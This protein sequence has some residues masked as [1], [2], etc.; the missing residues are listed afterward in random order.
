MSEVV[1]HLRNEW[2][3]PSPLAGNRVHVPERGDR[4]GSDMA[5]IARLTVVAV[6][7][8][9]AGP[10]AVSAADES[11]VESL[12]ELQE[13]RKEVDRRKSAMRKELRLLREVLGESAAE[14]AE[15]YRSDRATGALKAKELAAELRLLREELE[16]VRGAI[17]LPREDGD[18]TRF[19]VGGQ[20]RTRLEWNDEDFNNGRADVLQLLRSRL[21][22]EGY[23]EEHTKVV[24]EVQDARLYGSEV[25]TLDG[26]GDRVDFHQAFVTVD[27]FYD[28]PVRISIGR[29]ELSYGSERLVGAEGWSN[30][31]RSFD[32][33]K[34]RYGAESYGEVL[35]AKLGERGERDLNLWGA[36]GHILRRG[37]TFEPYALFEHDKSSTDRLRRLTM[38]LWAAGEFASATNQIL[39][40][41]VE[42]AFQGGDRGTGDI[43]AW[44]A[45]GRLIYKGTGWTKPRV[46]VGLDWLSGDDDPGD[47]DDQVFDTLFATNHRY[48]GL[49][50]LF[51]DIPRDTDR[52]GLVDVM[53]K[54]ELW[55]SE[56]VR[57]GVQVHQFSLA[58]GAGGKNLGQ[59][60]DAVATFRFNDA[61]SVDWGGLIFVPGSAM[62][63]R[64]NGEDPAFKTYFHS[65][66]NF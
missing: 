66:V 29:Q 57:V 42:G 60:A 17:E 3:R 37:H 14:A 25:N 52:R 65:S 28:R 62:K 49:M 33:V 4:T 5:A 9:S 36:Y 45:A 61:F 51:T 34:L 24:V 43:V 15:P 50:D 6:L 16:A 46:E 12:K 1:C 31:G 38:G 32:A 26:S 22:V 63:V 27:E 64:R 56:N 13:L 35:N 23:P 10:G 59:E 39:G 30:V 53:L 19:S 2:A 48:Y 20:V 41:E 18:P 7:L 47:S 40:Y 21:R 55:A 44:M 54:G 58:S 11:T 8:A